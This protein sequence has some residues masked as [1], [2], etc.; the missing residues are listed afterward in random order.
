VVELVWLI[1]AL[2]LI[3]FVVLLLAGKLLGEPRAGWIATTAAGASFLV[4]LMV[5]VG[6][7][8]RDSHSGER[9]YELILF[10]WLPSGS[11]Q[12]EAGFLVDPLSVTM[13]LF[14]T[15]VGA[16]IH[17]YSV[18]YMHGDPKYSKFFLYLN[19]F[20][21][22]MLMLV[23]GNNLVVTF[24]GWEG[25]GA[26]SY[27]LISFWHHRDSAAT[28]GK[29][30]FVTNRVGDWGFLVA[31]F[32]IWSALGTVTYTEIAS[33]PAMTAATG[34]AVSLLLFVAAAGKS[35]QLPLYVWLPDAMEGPTPV[36]AMV[37]AATMV[38]SG[39]YLLVR[40][41]NVLTDDALI[42]IA[43]VGAA[44]ALF[45]ALCAVAQ[46]DIKKVLAYSTISQLG[47]MFLAIGSG[48]YVAAIFHVITHSFFKALL[49]LGS[50]S[51]IHG[52]GDEQDMRKMGALRLAMPIT[53]ATFIVGWLAIAGVPPFA[54]F[55][56]KDEILLAAWEQKNIGPLLWGV[57][58]ITA[59]LTAYYMSRQVILVFF[60]DQRWDEDAHPHES[61]WTMTIPLCVLAG[62]A[63]VGGAIN[64]PLVKDWLVLEHFLE[65]I[66]NDPHHFSSGTIT[67]VA[68]AVISVCAAVAGISLAVLSWL[69]R[70]IS[71]DRLEPEFLENAMY[72]D[73]TYARVVDGIGTSSF[74]GAA[75]IDKRFVDGTVNTVGKLTM[76]LGRLIRPAQSGY[77]RNYAVGV[78]LG[79]L[80]IVAFLT[81][82]LLL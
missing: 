42:V 47:F 81:W 56:S 11:L 14:V 2:P 70:Q 62:A 13:A 48:A 22:S 58:L 27:L 9:S 25:V 54:G 69:T 57:G 17:L 36:S 21:F 52:M 30:A 4:T 23:F 7:L 3:G 20:L 72:V 35:A 43:V 51:V 79:A 12:V 74:Q 76:R 46:H 37:H 34:T 78:A 77:I 31:T 38:T 64:L 10:E 66:F 53:A 61:S 55:W 45:A 39:V 49:F 40:M 50:G 75:D 26:C 41:N 82:G 73:S 59:L 28:A 63:I 33:S 6:L 1:P 68:L 8:G 32:A 44:T 65:P 5:F 67:K 24:L 15:G 18:G 71:T 19:L 60:G 80:V 29:K 16:L